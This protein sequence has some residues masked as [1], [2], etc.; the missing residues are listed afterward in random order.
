M[1]SNSAWFFTIYVHDQNKRQTLSDRSRYATSVKNHTNNYIRGLVR[2]LRMWDLTFFTFCLNG[3][4]IDRS[5]S[6][7]SILCWLIFECYI[8]QVEIKSAVPRPIMQAAEM[9]TEAAR[10][11]QQLDLSLKHRHGEIV[12]DSGI[13]KIFHDTAIGSPSL[14][15]NAWHLPQ[16]RT[17]A[18]SYA[19]NSNL[20]GQ[21]D[22]I[23]SGGLEISSVPLPLTHGPRPQWLLKLRSWLPKFLTS[24]SNR[25]F[26]GE[27]YPLSSLKGDFRYKIHSTRSFAQI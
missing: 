16:N 19:E 13:C 1:S 25:L 27:W 5:Y 22:E 3:C 26:E 7:H 14:G 2:L 21:S 18:I 4:I 24:V 20:K 9:S 11:Q 12:Q 8:S 6:N 17:K 23:E 10:N 15:E